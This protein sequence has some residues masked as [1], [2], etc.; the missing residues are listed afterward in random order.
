MEQ[1]FIGTS[2]WTY[3]SWRGGFYPKY[4]LPRSYLSFYAHTFATTEINCS[5]YRL[6]HTGSFEK[7]AA[8]VPRNFLFSV[9]ANRS[10]THVGRLRNVA[11]AWR[12][13][14]NNATCLV[15]HLSDPSCSNFLLVSPGHE[16]EGSM[17]RVASWRC[18][19]GLYCLS[20]LFHD[21][22]VIVSMLSC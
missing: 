8:L 10:I 17:A 2:G 7:W 9:K 16:P 21:D 6:P 3:K 4:L 14:V 22:K 5:F 13:F 20:S 19:G 18:V 1:I 12:G 11:D 15:S